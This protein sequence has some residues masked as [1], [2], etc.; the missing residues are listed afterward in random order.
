M[1]V[2]TLREALDAD[3][4]AEHRA[5]TL[6]HKVRDVAEDTKDLAIKGL[7]RR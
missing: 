6:S 2:K 1:I 5:R 4:K 7:S 3:L